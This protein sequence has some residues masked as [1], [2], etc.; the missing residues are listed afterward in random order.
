M[1]K[2][3]HRRLSAT[4]R[5]SLL[6]EFWSLLDALQKA[7]GLRTFLEGFLTPSERVMFARRLQIATHLMEGRTTSEIRER[8]G[9]GLST[10]ESVDRWL[11]RG[12]GDYRRTLPEIIARA[13]SAQGRTSPAPRDI[14]GTF[15]DIRR[16][17]PGYF[18]LLNWILD[19]KL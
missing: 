18:L 12:F 10:I 15:T 16:R 8:L 6:G 1:A 3:D 7:R 19:G 4:E 13:R 5:S 2:F 9:V 14:R 11:E 17:N